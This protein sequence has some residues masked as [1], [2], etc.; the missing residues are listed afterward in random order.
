MLEG[1]SGAVIRFIPCTAPKGPLWEGWCFAQRIKNDY[2]CTTR[3]FLRFA[4][5]PWQSYKNVWHGVSRD[6]GRECSIFGKFSKIGTCSL[7]QSRC[8]R[9]SS[10]I[11][12]S[13]GALPRQRVFSTVSACPFLG[14]AFLRCRRWI[15]CIKIQKQCCR[16][17]NTRQRRE[18]ARKPGN[19]KE[20]RGSGNGRTPCRNTCIQREIKEGNRFRMGKTENVIG[21]DLVFR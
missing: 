5:S 15:I 1:I 2:D 4:Q 13:L 6:W 12:G 17:K 3:A 16:G 19:L 8:S 20:S 9:D 11:R 7:P 14:Q 21:R 18:F 10:L